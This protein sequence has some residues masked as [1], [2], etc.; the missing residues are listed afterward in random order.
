MPKKRKSTGETDGSPVQKRV[1]QQQPQSSMM[2]IQQ[3]DPQLLQDGQSSTPQPVTSAEYEQPQPEWQNGHVYPDPEAGFDAQAN[4]GPYHN[5]NNTNVYNFASLQQFANDV[6]DL[7]GDPNESAIHPDLRGPVQ[8][9]TAPQV[10]STEEANPVDNVSQMTGMEIA[11]GGDKSM[12]AVHHVSVD[13]GVSMPDDVAVKTAEVDQ[14]MNDGVENVVLKPAGVDGE[15]NGTAARESDLQDTETNDM[16]Q[17]IEKSATATAGQALAIEISGT[18]QT[19]VKGYAS[20]VS[21]DGVPYSTWKSPE[22]SKQME[23]QPTPP[24]SPL[25]AMET[26]PPPQ[27]KTT[28]TT[29]ASPHRSRAQQ[30]E[31]QQVTGS[32]KRKSTTPTPDMVK[33][34]KS[35]TPGAE[36]A[37]NK[38]RRSSIAPA[39]GVERKLSQSELQ[40]EESLRLAREMQSG[41]FGLRRRKSV[42]GL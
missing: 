10:M 35:S 1:K 26:S 34:R 24:S 13:S 29:V 40:D 3:Y 27:D 36:N 18:G 11:G 33:K 16:I 21:A 41:G 25:T 7:N 28:V 37:V 17:R 19:P 23:P 42:A 6:L 22:I 39:N 38:K 14:R 31:S 12:D 20:K 4:G 30:A 8:A 9:P 32:K 15:S 5:L 2:M